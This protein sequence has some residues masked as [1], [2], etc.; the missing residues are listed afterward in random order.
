MSQ[1]FFTLSKIAE[2]AV[3]SEAIGKCSDVI[4]KLGGEES[5]V[6]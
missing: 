4:I 5:K 3:P 6:R 2:S 1:G